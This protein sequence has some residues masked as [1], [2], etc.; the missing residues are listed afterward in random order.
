MCYASGIDEAEAVRETIAVLK[1]S[2]MSP[3]NVSGY[4]SIKERIDEG[5]DLDDHD[6]EFMEK[7]LKESAEVISEISPV[8]DN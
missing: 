7:A 3:L 4:G 1:I 8:L 5:D 6:Y 2:G